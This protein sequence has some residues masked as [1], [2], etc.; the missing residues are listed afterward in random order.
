LDVA[1]CVVHFS[2]SNSFGDYYHDSEHESNFDGLII[3]KY[4]LT[5]IN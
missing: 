1:N 5:H 4:S 2:P 3:S